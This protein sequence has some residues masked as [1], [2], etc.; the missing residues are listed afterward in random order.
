VQSAFEQN[1]PKSFA[2]PVETIIW[3]ARTRQGK[4]EAG[5]GVLGPQLAGNALTAEAPG[6]F[7]YTFYISAIPADE[8]V[9]QPGC[10][11]LYLETLTDPGVSPTAK[12]LGNKRLPIGTAL[13][14][15]YIEPASLVEAIRV[16]EGHKDAAKL[17]IAERIRAARA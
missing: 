17:S 4:E 15:P 13:D 9:K 10:H 12:V 8:L 1:V 2:I 14:K 11:R 3:T 6:W 16:I 5:G 7:I